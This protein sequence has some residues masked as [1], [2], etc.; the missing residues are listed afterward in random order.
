MAK[1]AS[2]KQNKEQNKN[3]HQSHMPAVKGMVSAGKGIMRNQGALVWNRVLFIGEFI[4]SKK[5]SC[6][7]KCR[8]CNC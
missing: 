8:L 7:G 6:H 5:T 3:Q 4:S 2:W 1:Q